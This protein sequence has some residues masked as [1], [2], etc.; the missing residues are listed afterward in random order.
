MESS[1]W[2][3]DMEVCYLDTA[4]GDEG[5]KPVLLMLHGWGASKES[6][7][8]VVGALE[9]RYRVIAP[10]LPGSGKTGE[11]G[12][13]WTAG[14][15]A[16]FIQSFIEAL[17]LSVGP[18]FACGHSHGGRILIKWA[19][20]YKGGLKR[21]ILIDSA[22]LRPQRGPA[23]YAKVYGYKA[24]KKL[25]GAPVLGK[26]LAPL[27]RD[28]LA[29]AGSADYRL[30]SPLM[31]RTMSLLLEEDLSRCLPL[32]KVPTLIFWGDKDEDTPLAMGRKMEKAIPDAGL[33]V[34]S[35]AGH[36]SYLDQLPSFLATLCYFLEH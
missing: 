29:E 14:D 22:G 34:L 7:A 28:W 12:K 36:Y 13:P 35:P 32:I 10:D 8:P 33:V 31:R 9:G 24:G 16:F 20:L 5:D 6:F 27:V 3:S 21:L 19:S 17:G 23:W 30:A 26:L 11:P 18:Y 1:L 15:Y 4:P 2:L 25:L